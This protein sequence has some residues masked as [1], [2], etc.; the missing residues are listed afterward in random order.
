[1]QAYLDLYRRCNNLCRCI[2]EGNSSIEVSAAVSAFE[3][4]ETYDAVELMEGFD[5]GCKASSKFGFGA[6]PPMVVGF[7][8]E[9]KLVFGNVYQA[10]CR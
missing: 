3:V 4:T 10:D 9:R 1:M 7:A 6:N 5:F 8:E 2:D